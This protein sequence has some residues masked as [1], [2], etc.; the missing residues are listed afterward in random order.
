MLNEIVK[1]VITGA[2]VTINS[3]VLPPYDLKAEIII[4]DKVIPKPPVDNR[5]FA[6]ILLNGHPFKVDESYLD[7]PLDNFYPIYDLYDGEEVGTMQASTLQK[8][9]TRVPAC[10][11]DIYADRIKACIE[12]T[13]S[14]IDIRPVLRLLVNNDKF[15][16]YVVGPV[17]MDDLIVREG[18]QYFAYAQGEDGEPVLYV[19]DTALEL[20][21][22]IKYGITKCRAR[23]VSFVHDKYIQEA[24]DKLKAYYL[25]GDV[26]AIN[27]LYSAWKDGTAIEPETEHNHEFHCSWCLANGLD[28]KHG[29]YW[30]NDGNVYDDGSHTTRS[31]YIKP[32]TH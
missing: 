29:N 7:E 26:C 31:N 21:E 27:E 23:N 17:L 18:G 11:I 25:E 30:S 4:D 20:R 10:Y 6:Y 3:D 22:N 24:L 13:I 1:P 12:T 15:I 16:H 32:H 8:I 2:K 5:V 19:G 28:G 14:K 9:A